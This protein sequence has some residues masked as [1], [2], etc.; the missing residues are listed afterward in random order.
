MAAGE[1]P[2]QVV[3][4]SVPAWYRR[5]RPVALL[6]RS[7]PVPKPLKTM[8]LALHNLR[9]CA[10]HSLPNPQSPKSYGLR[11]GSRR[12]VDA[13]VVERTKVHALCNIAFRGV[14]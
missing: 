13:G 12:L 6:C 2:I 5:P 4:S 8:I 1:R 11:V 10:S 14:A 9:S 7:D 3:V